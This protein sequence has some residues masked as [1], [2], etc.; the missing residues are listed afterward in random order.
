[1]FIDMPP[2]TGDVPLTVFQS[3]P[4]DGIIVVTSPQELVSMIVQKAVRMA[5]MMDIPVLALVENL[6]YFEC[7]GCHERFEIFGQSQTESVAEQYG[8][9]VTAK[10]PVDPELSRASDAGSIEA[11]EK[12]WLTPVVDRLM[13]MEGLG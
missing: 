11:Y 3:I 4:I 13:K 7:P 6:S 1:M 12:Q 9:G 5:S 8:I 10:I 2:G